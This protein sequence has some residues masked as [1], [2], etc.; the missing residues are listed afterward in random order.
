MKNPKQTLGKMIRS[1]KAEATKKIHDAGYGKFGWQGK[2][3]DHIIRNG[4][5]L[6]RIRQ[7]I[8]DNPMNWERDD[9]FPGNIRMDR[10][11]DRP[12]DWSALD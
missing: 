1:F 10:T 3:H 5:D 8:I 2:Y 6:D 7:Y 12:E 11:H 9:N 4:T